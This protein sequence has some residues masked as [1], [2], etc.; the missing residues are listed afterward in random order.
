MNFLQEFENNIAKAFFSQKRSIRLPQINKVC[1]YYSQVFRSNKGDIRLD[2]K[3]AHKSPCDMKNPKLTV[4]RHL[5][6]TDN[7]NL[8]CEA[9][10][11]HIKE[12]ILCGVKFKVPERKS[13]FIRKRLIFHKGK[14]MNATQTDLSDEDQ[15]KSPLYPSTK[16]QLY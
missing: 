11:E 3:I 1:S 8:S 10:D 13:A 4:R 12:N 5:K 15:S 16:G 6:N 2:Q 7:R 9:R 14:V